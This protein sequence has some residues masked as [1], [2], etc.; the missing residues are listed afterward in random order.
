MPTAASDKAG[1]GVAAVSPLTSAVLLQGTPIVALSA[2]VAVFTLGVIQALHACSRPLVTGLWVHGVDVVVALAWLAGTTN[3]IRAPKEAR[4]TFFT[5]TACVNK[6]AQWEL[7]SRLPSAQ[8]HNQQGNKDHYWGDINRIMFKETDS[9]WSDY[10]NLVQSMDG[11]TQNTK[12]RCSSTQFQCCPVHP[13]LSTS[14]P[15]PHCCWR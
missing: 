14:H 12:A 9:T 3:L 11:T 5:S 15:S 10:G 1:A 6:Q 7:P 2:E 13:S 8:L 4:R